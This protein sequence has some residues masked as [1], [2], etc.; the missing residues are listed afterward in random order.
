VLFSGEKLKFLNVLLRVVFMAFKAKI[1]KKVPKVNTA[2][3]EELVHY[4]VHRLGDKPNFGAT[5]LNKI[6][7]FSDFDFYEINY[8]SITN[9]SYRKIQFGPAPCNL[10]GIEKKLIREKK[11]LS[12]VGEFYGHKQKKFVCV[13]APEIKSLNSDE[14]KIIDNVIKKL[15]S[16]TATQVSEY[17][18]LDIPWKA[19]KDRQIIDYELVFHRLPITAVT[20]N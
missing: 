6:L 11:I 14:L 9:E 19:T 15:S 18:H 20:E 4:I 17:S 12:V 5:L 10:A 3:Y 2:K 16:F 13:Q 7:Y 8:K 1:Y